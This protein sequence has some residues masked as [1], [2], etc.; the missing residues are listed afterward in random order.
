[1]KNSHNK[2]NRTI[3]DISLSNDEIKQ[4]AQARQRAL[5]APKQRFFSSF[6]TPVMAYASL[7]LAV[8]IVSF[9]L[10]NKPEDRINQTPQ[11][12]EAFTLISSQEPVELYE[13]LEF[14]MWLGVD[15]R[16]E[17]KG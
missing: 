17:N 5:E 8:G 10:F 3:D 6:S 9:S 16:N 2:I 15:N 12:D 1:M 7:F 13:N 11:F 14:Y 4:L